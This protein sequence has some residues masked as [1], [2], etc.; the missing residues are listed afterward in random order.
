M[1]KLIKSLQQLLQEQ[2]SPDKKEWWENYMKHVISFRGIGIPDIRETVKSWYKNEQISV[3]PLESRLETTM[4]LLKEPLAE[5]K[6]AGILILQL[7][8]YEQIGFKTLIKHFEKL[9][10]Q[11]AI[12]D[13]NTCDWFC[14]RVLGPMISLHGTPCAETILSWNQADYLWQARASVVAFVYL[15]E[16]KNFR[17]G[18]VTACNVLIQREERFAKTAVGW[19]LRKLA[20]HNRKT[21]DRFLQRNLKH[22]TNEVLRNAAKHFE[23]QEKKKWL[24]QLKSIK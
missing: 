22:F 13:W 12:F 2:A 23:P 4:Q 16:N 17:P 9:F 11:K 15:L 3:L 8:L 24:Q 6:L 21:V 1:H 20:K 14:I 5:D 18:L 10:D 7:F 19:V